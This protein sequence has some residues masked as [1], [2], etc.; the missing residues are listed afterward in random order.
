MKKI[1]V[2]IIMPAYNAERTLERALNSCIHQTLQEIE[3]IVIDDYSQDSTL[4]ILKEVQKEYPNKVRIIFQSENKKQGAARNAGIEVASGEY[5]LFVDSDD[6]LESQACEL[7]YS[8]AIKSNA[9]VVCGDYD[10]VWPD[11]RRKQ[12]KVYENALEC[13][14]TQ[15]V[16]TKKKLLMQ[17]G[18]FWCKL[19]RKS[20]LDINRIRFPEG[21]YY[22]DSA[23]NTLTMLATNRIEKVNYIFY[24]YF[25]NDTSTVHKT[26]NQLDKIKVAQYLLK[27]KSGFNECYG[28]L[29]DYKAAV[30]TGA[31]LIY[32]VIPLHKQL[33]L[34]LN[35]YLEEIR[36]NT[37]QMRPKEGGGYWLAPSDMLKAMELNYKHPLLFKLLKLR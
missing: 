7:L 19:Y 8:C 9:D 11:G 5:I 22:E 33:G 16:E 24:H 37:A 36:E 18:Y 26:E 10:W 34:G 30:L 2:S 4:K 23:F 27:I 21:L 12:I 15:T 25:Q 29:I 32:A 17:P 35:S 13:I 6:W 3:V 20:M 31:A 14:G 1:K 28:E